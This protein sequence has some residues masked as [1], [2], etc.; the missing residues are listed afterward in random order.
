MAW[1]PNPSNSVTFRA[2]NYCLLFTPD[3][4]FPEFAITVLLSRPSPSVDWA[5]FYNIGTGNWAQS[6]ATHGGWKGWITWFID[7]ANTGVHI[8][9]GDSNPIP[10][11]TIPE[12]EPQTFAECQAWLVKWL[13]FVDTPTTSNGYLGV[14]PT[15][16]PSGGFVANRALDFGKQRVILSLQVDQDGKAVM[17]CQRWIGPGPDDWQSV[18][19]A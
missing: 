5:A 1:N 2:N 7:Q 12:G 8:N 3:P 19:F 17:K 10:P 13:Y 15:P 11:V 14:K 16:P 9:L 18:P 4:D 6:V